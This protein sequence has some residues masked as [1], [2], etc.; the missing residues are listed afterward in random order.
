MPKSPRPV[1]SISDRADRL[2]SCL[3]NVVSMFHVIQKEIH[4]RREQGIP[5]GFE[6]LQKYKPIV[7]VGAE[8]PLGD[9][10]EMAAHIRECGT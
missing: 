10:R 7:A 4:W 9:L 8:E 3:R 5:E 2:S 6:T 1:I